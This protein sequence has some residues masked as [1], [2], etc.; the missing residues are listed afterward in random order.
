MQVIV[1]S[2]AAEDNAITGELLSNTTVTTFEF[3]LEAHPL[4][5]FVTTILYEP[6]ALNTGFAVVSVP[7][8]IPTV[9]VQL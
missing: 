8:T 1:P 6:A 7:G 3:I 2:F 5:V 9:G 4:K